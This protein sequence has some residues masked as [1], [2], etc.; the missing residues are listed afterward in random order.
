M[1]H[2]RSAHIDSR[3]TDNVETW[4]WG[5]ESEK[6]IGKMSERVGCLLNHRRFLTG[7]V[8]SSFSRLRVTAYSA[9]SQKCGNDDTE[10]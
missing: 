5:K 10:D 1:E 8:H 7:K 2:D 9:N 4:Q 3:G 6:W